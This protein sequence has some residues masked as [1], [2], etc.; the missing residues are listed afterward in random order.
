MRHITLSLLAGAVLGLLA[1]APASAAP[2]DLGMDMAGEACRLSGTDILCG[3]AEV[4]TGSVHQVAMSAALPAGDAAR[5]SAI[6][7][8]I[9]AL[10]ENGAASGLR[11]DGGKAID[12]TSFLY[13]C[14]SGNGD[15]PLIA[16]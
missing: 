2:G 16:T 15:A 12:A 13:V 8:A 9:R 3:T 11:C 6:A 4:K 5:R 7:S 14:N 1:A 10:P